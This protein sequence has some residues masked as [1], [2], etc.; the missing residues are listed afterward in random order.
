[1]PSYTGRVGIVQRVLPRY[2]APFF[3]LLASQCERGLSVFAGA[4][5][6]SESI[7]IAEKLAIAKWTQAG[8]IHLFGGPFYLCWQRGLIQW[9]AEWDPDVL[10]VEANPRYVSTPAA[11]AWMK[12]RSRPVIG[13]GLGSPIPRGPVARLR[14]QAR[15]RFVRQF[16]ALIAYSR[17]GAEEYATLGFPAGRVFVA[18]NAVSPRPLGKPPEQPPA[19]A[20]QATV[21]YVGRLQSR[22]RLQNLIRAFV[23]LPEQPRLVIVGDGPQRQELEALARQLHPGTEFRGALFGDELEIAFKEADLFVLP[24]TGGLAVQQ[25]MAHG[26]PVIAAE[27]DGSQEDMVTSANGWLLPPRDD[28]ALGAALTEALSNP[29]RLRKMGSESFR[30]VQE[31]FNLEAMAGAFVEAIHEVAR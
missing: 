22:K 19:F 16:D 28:V 14:I 21:L 31:K 13:W 18:P 23:G 27:G 20:G 12:K 3:D 8:N 4:A 29:A 15:K 30:L 9:L 7:P 11:L 6:P 10:I 5:R 1:M 24:G 2:R 17:R 26:L 25:A